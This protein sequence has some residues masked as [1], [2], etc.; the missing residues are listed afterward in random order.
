MPAPT[1]LTG[2]ITSGDKADDTLLPVL[3]LEN[4]WAF[5]WLGLRLLTPFRP[6]FC[7]LIG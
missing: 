1:G 7:S 2:E 3:L 6:I 5:V 4:G